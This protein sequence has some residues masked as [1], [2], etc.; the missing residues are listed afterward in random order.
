MNKIVMTLM[1]TCAL[2]TGVASAG[3]FSTLARRA[4]LVKEAGSDA[5]TLIETVNKKQQ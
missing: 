3:D 4:D 2:S 1:L 5:K